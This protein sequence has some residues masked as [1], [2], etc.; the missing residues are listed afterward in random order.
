MIFSKSQN[1]PEAYTKWQSQPPKRAKN[2][3]SCRPQGRF[4]NPPKRCKWVF[5]QKMAWGLHGR[6]IF[7]SSRFLQSKPLASQ[8]RWKTLK[9]HSRVGPNAKTKI[10]HLLH[11]ALKRF[12][13]FK[14][15]SSRHL[16]PSLVPSCTILKLDT[17]ITNHKKQQ[18][19]R[20]HK[21]VNFTMGF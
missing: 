16:R 4:Q 7:K 13:L 15:S 20:R 8:T 2:N 10:I 6:N 11:P 3:V 9:L 5:S 18:N 17:A 19:R 14:K 1:G 12:E 21:N